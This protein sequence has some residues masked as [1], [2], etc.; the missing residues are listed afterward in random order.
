MSVTPRIVGKIDC[1]NSWCYNIVIKRDVCQIFSDNQAKIPVKC[2]HMYVEIFN[3][4]ARNSLPLGS[5]G[6][7]WYDIY[8]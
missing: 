3:E 8:G 5:V 7:N 2:H 1:I 6:K 4:N